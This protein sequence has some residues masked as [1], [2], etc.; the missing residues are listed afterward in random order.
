MLNENRTLPLRERMSTMKKITILGL[1]LVLSIL[2]FIPVRYA[3][4]ASIQP[5]SW[6]SA[7]SGTS[8][9][10]PITLSKSSGE[11]VSYVEFS[12]FT[13]QNS[14]LTLESVSVASGYIYGVENGKITIFSKNGLS[15]GALCTLTF[16]TTSSSSFEIYFNTDNSAVSVNNS[17]W[18]D[19]QQQSV[20]VGDTVKFGR[21]KQN[22]IDTHYVI[23]PIEWRVLDVQDGKALL[24]SSKVLDHHV[25][26]PK[27]VAITWE[28]CQLRS[29]LNNDFL[30]I[31]FTQEEQH[32]IVLSWVPAQDNPLHPEKKPVIGSGND[33]YDYVFI[34]NVVEAL[35]YFPGRYDRIA[36]ATP[37][38]V[39]IGGVSTDKY[40]IN[41][42]TNKK[43]YRV[44]NS[45]WLLRQPHTHNT[46]T[47][48]VD[49][50]GDMSNGVNVSA[51]RSGLRPCIWVD[52]SKAN[53]SSSQI[54]SASSY[55]SSSVIVSQPTYNYN[56]SSPSSSSSSTNENAASVKKTELSRGWEKSISTSGVSTTTNAVLSL[57]TGPG[58]DY[59]YIGKY[60]SS[61]SSVRAISLAYD[62]YGTAWCMIEG[63]DGGTH[64]RG[65]AQASKLN[66]NINKL[67]QEMDSE[68]WT[69]GM[70][71]DFY[72]S[73]NLRTG[74]GDSYSSLNITPV[75][76]GE[77]M[78]IATEGDWAQVELA[79][80][81]PKCR[82][83]VEMSSLMY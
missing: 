13:S 46:D 16:S 40:D 82:V 5:Q 52:L 32:A 30:N 72:D 27:Q 53:L 1:A 51:E 58:T 48:C 7:Y 77:N 3:S 55:S 11:N 59:V 44:S 28:Y 69:S 34:L 57:Y 18:V 14:R 6:V 74:P 45:N 62:A 42:E 67:T 68:Q 64:C 8:F 33:T 65:Y 43:I 73:A 24:I 17:C 78:L 35:K 49:W 47:P 70:S 2:L 19:I 81:T 23:E 41:M 4:A 83:W 36:M 80:Q 20:S 66:V 29:W 79:Y 61:G 60:F 38:A 39:Y 9:E 37:Y 21:Y 26:H 15:S 71:A 63:W 25:Y 12:Y 54:S 22:W 31:A 50:F 10:V 56:S 75:N 76:C